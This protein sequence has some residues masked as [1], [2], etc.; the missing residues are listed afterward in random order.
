MWRMLQLDAPEDYVIGTGHTFS[1]RDFC[2]SAFSAVD[3]EWDKYVVQDERFFRRRR[4]I[5]WLPIHRRPRPNWDGSRRCRLKPR[6]H[7]GRSGHGSLQSRVAMKRALVTG[8][9]GFVGKWMCAA[10]VQDG[11]HVTGCA[12]SADDG[13]AAAKAA[14]PWGSLDGVE[15]RAGDLRDASFVQELFAAPYDAVVHLAAVSQVQHATTNPTLAWEVNL[16]ATVQL[17]NAAQQSRASGASDPVVLLVGSAEEYGRQPESVM[18]LTETTPLTPLT[19]YGA[20]KA[21]GET[22]G[23]QMH[24]AT[25]LK[26][27]VARPF[28]HTGPGQEERFV[29][30]A[31]VARA[32]GL[33]RGGERGANDDG[34]SH[35]GSRFS[36]RE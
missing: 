14:G 32:E 18:P 9:A 11:W 4:L 23:L 1:V 22:A 8:A 34:K 30:P 36:S 3:L 12:H 7:D 15:W 24:R 28:P 13:V 6:A 26:V 10:L 2:E 35:T 17:L 21:A 5:C 25:G 33:R 19:V 27:V 16:L 20:T 29:L 31:M